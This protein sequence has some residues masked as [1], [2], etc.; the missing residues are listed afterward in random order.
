[1]RPQVSM[2]ALLLLM[3]G[4]SLLFLRARPSQDVMVTEHGVPETEAEHVVVNAPTPAELRALPAASAAAS[5]RPAPALRGES[6]ATRA[7]DDERNLAPAAAPAAVAEETT[8]GAA[9]P[10]ALGASDAATDTLE[11][12]TAAFQ[13]GRY[14]EAQRRFEE[15]AARGGSDAPVASLQAVEALRRQ[16][17]CP[18]AAPRY[19]E[20]HSKYPDTSS[21]N[22]AAWQAGDCYR[23][24]GDLP[25]ARQ[26][27]ESLLNVS[28]Y[29][30][31]AQA[32][33]QE[34]TAREEQLAS[35]RK[36]KAGAPAAA[37]VPASPPADVK[38]AKPRAETIESQ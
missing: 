9:E 26:T 23:A 10:E 21:G 5:P 1:M 35:A 32:A 24:L 36:A 29:R 38:A 30:A 2:A 4:S 34:L 19:D 27:L 28:E 12:A 22:E 8:K 16:R 25:R 20:V 3:I 31:R 6:V 37:P 14:V 17:G 18:A 11:G 33:L 7:H 13:G 15:I